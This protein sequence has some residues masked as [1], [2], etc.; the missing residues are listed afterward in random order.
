MPNFMYARSNVLKLEA[1]KMEGHRIH[2]VPQ[3]KE[4]DADLRSF[5]IAVRQCKFQEESES[6][7][8][9][10]YTQQNCIFGG[11][12]RSGLHQSDG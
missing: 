10:V 2:L 6:S 11:P 4:F 1:N 5:P 12:D 8:F 3:V 9:P 7:L